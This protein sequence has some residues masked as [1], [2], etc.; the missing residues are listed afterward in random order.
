[1]TYEKETVEYVEAECDADGCKNFL[2][3][4]KVREA[5]NDGWLFYK[6]SR[7]DRKVN[8]AFCPQHRALIVSSI[9]EFF[10]E[11]DMDE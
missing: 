8:K 7:G 6:A 2:K 1:M 5:Y 4:K 3:A 10:K 11:G 9:D